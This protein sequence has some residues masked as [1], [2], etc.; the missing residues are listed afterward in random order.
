MKI[1]SAI[2]SLEFGDQLLLFRE[3]LSVLTALDGNARMIWELIAS[4]L[5]PRD[6]SLV[7][8]EAS[9]LPF[10]QVKIDIDSV[11]ARLREQGLFGP[12]PIV[13]STQLS[14]PASVP[15][16]FEHEA[17]YAIC[18]QPVRL[19]FETEALWSDFEP[20]FAPC[21]VVGAPQQARIDVFYD[22]D[23]IVVAMADKRFQRAE[24][25]ADVMGMVINSIFD[26]S[27]PEANWIAVL[28][29]AAVSLHGKAYILAGTKGR[30]KSTLTANLLTAGFGFLSDDVVP[31]DGITRQAMPVPLPLC[32]K[33][34]SW[35]LF[36]DTIPG[37]ADRPVYRDEGP[38]R[39]Y[40]DMRQHCHENVRLGGDVG[41]LIFPHY[42]AGS[43]ASI[44]PISPMDAL[45]LLVSS[46]SWVSLRK[47]DFE[48]FLGLLAD[49]TT[50]KINYPDKE[51]SIAMVKEIV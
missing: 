9:D 11:L 35:P 38:P 7:L 44:Q 33:E 37:L 19:R 30:G 21:R 20:Y 50:V 10:D 6:A 40:I 16:A 22:E 27:F 18:H 13:N 45:Q 42:M 24:H 17:C 41:A 51:S 4:G 26:L 23:T 15:E 34:A 8:T 3:D 39:R 1:S 2:E 36:E 49:I 14:A 12:D 5:S 46:D 31:I 47:Q 48:T 32:L 28:H 29:A 43:Q 25:P